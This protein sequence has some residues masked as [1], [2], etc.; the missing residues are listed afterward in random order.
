MNTKSIPDTITGTWNRLGNL[1]KSN[2]NRWEVMNVSDW[3]WYYFL[4]IIMG[5]VTV[6]GLVAWI[7]WKDDI[8]AKL[9]EGRKSEIPDSIPIDE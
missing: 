1:T 6:F 2:N 8:K 5:L 4:G 7:L 9:A 3:K